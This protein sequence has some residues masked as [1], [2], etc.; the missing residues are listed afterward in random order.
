MR[1]IARRR[2][3]FQV[4]VQHDFFRGGVDLKQL[5]LLDCARAHDTHYFEVQMHL[6]L[7]AL[8]I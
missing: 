3:N 2:Q 7:F 8:E 5:N 1:V 6:P 4:L